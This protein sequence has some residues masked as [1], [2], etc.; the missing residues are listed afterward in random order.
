MAAASSSGF[1]TGFLSGTALSVV[2]LIGLAVIVPLETPSSLNAPLP[3]LPETAVPVEDTAQVDTE[4]TGLPAI[5]SPAEPSSTPAVDPE[6]PREDIALAP[7]VSGSS[8]SETVVIGSV[9]SSDA[10]RAEA[11]PPPPPSNTG[12]STQATVTGTENPD[13]VQLDQSA[14]PAGALTAAPAPDAALPQLP[15]ATTDTRQALLVPQ[16]PAAPLAATPPVAP[17]A[18]APP[19]PPPPAEEE[20]PVEEAPTTFE[21]A[22]PIVTLPTDQVAAEDAPFRQFAATY[23]V[24]GNRPLM[25]VILQDAGE[26]GIEIE[27]LSGLLFPVSFAIPVDLPDAE[28]RAAAYRAAGFEVLAMLPQ[29]DE[30]NLEGLPEEQLEALYAVALSRVPEAIGLVD[31]INGDIPQDTTISRSFIDFA[32]RTGH[33]LVT[34]RDQGFNSVDALAEVAGVPSATIFR[35]LGDG[36]DTGA[37]RDNL[38]RAAVQAGGSGA[39]LVLGRTDRATIT[40]LFAWVLGSGGTQSVD[41]APVSALITRQQ[42]E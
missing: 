29:G 16:A 35:V 11:P 30:G 41:L 18:V 7:V 5:A 40:T 13:R 21:P 42:Q 39:V 34:H 14:S 2:T 1:A 37:L 4:S 26:D 15:S 25:S 24:E 12:L 38:D 8:T 10:I 32:A 28:E 22:A 36:S 27:A 6:I 3:G 9:D 19:P 23:S 31:R 33:A 17:A 20:E